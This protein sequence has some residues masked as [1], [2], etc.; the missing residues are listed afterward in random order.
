MD[1]GTDDA[2]RDSENEQSNSSDEEVATTTRGGLDRMQGTGE[3]GATVVR[4]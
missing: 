1:Q 2:G 3:A 4:V